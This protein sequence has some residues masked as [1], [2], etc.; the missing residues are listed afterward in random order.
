MT[1]KIYKTSRGRTID[2]GSLLLQNEQVRA[3]GNMNVNARGDLLDSGNRVIDQKNRQVQRQYKKQTNVSSAPVVA[4][5]KQAKQVQVPETESNLE[6][7]ELVFEEDIIQENLSEPA[8]VESTAIPRGGLAAAIAK[9]KTI[10]QEPEK[11]LRELQP[12]KGLKKI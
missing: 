1:R 2:M 12:E 7:D 8:P 3:V 4:S 5:T 6:T 11:T 9:A 10:K